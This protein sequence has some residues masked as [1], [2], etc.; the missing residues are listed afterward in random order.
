MKTRLPLTRLQ[1][2]DAL[3]KGLGRAILHARKH[4]LE[5]MHGELKRAI[6]NNLV[7]DAQCEWHRPAWL[8]KL[9]RAGRCEDRYRSTILRG[10][11]TVN[12]Y[13]LG[14]QLSALTYRFA[15][16]GDAQARKALY[17]A[18]NRFVGVDHHEIEREIMLLDGVKGLQKVADRI[19]REL[20]QGGDAWTLHVESIWWN[21]KD[22]FGAAKVRRALMR[23]SRLGKIFLERAL[24]IEGSNKKDRRARLSRLKIE[25]P[26][27]KTWAEFRS[28]LENIKVRSVSPFLFAKH[29]TSKELRSAY[30][31]LAIERRPLQ[32]AKLLHV[33]VRRRPPIWKPFLL[34][35]ARSSDDSVQGFA[36][37]VLA[38]FRRPEVRRLALAAARRRRDVANGALCVFG[39]NYRRG[40]RDIILAALSGVWKDHD[41]EHCIAMS[42]LAIAEGNMDR[43]LAPVYS[44]AY[45]LT[46]CAL[47]RKDL[48]KKLQSMKSAPEWMSEECVEDALDDTRSLARKAVK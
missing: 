1:F 7:Y 10:M 19:G 2:R 48:F 11:A 40:D 23:G 31:A 24:M 4:G 13:R 36:W 29:A 14:Q 32:S 47:C 16:V 38:H 35:F 26:K 17:A 20:S 28:D 9:M 8:W 34:A 6:V 22:V 45:G 44:E 43:T 33:F 27:R 25:G 42:V 15:R 39:K 3:E 5:G 12:E 37:E 41:E 30:E 18:F 21:A 46:P